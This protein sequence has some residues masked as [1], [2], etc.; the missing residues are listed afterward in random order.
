MTLANK[1]ILIVGGTSGN[2]FATAQRAAEA[3]A[4]PI[5]AGRSRE[6]LAAALAKLP[7]GAQAEELDFADAASVASL[8]GRLLGRTSA[9]TLR[10]LDANVIVEAGRMIVEEDMPA[11][12]AAGIQEVKIRSVLTCEAPNGVCGSPGETARR[13][14]DW[15]CHRLVHAPQPGRHRGG[16]RLRPRPRAGPSCPL[17]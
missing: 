11:I 17:A 9:E 16:A 3:G 5:I 1:V 13:R 15:P 12:N 4:T 7:R 10:D 8:A 6:R 2:G 14:R